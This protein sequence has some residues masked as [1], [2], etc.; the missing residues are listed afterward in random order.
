[1]K[2]NNHQCSKHNWLWG[3][4]D[5]EDVS[6]SKNIDKWIQIWRI[7]NK[8]MANQCANY[9][10]KIFW[11]SSGGYKK[12]RYYDYFIGPNTLSMNPTYCSKLVFHVF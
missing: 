3:K 8:G 9:A 2:N 7:P 5:Q 1:M 11:N 12:N 4:E 6:S 10:D